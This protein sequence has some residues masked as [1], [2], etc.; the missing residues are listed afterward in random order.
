MTR[1]ANDRFYRIEEMAELGAKLP[2]IAKRLG[3]QEKT[4]ARACARHGRWDLYRRIDLRHEYD[5]A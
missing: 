1:P 2:D 3:I 5:R 4:V